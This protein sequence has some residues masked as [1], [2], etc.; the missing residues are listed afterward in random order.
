[1]IL[2][3]KYHI[4]TRKC[5]N[6]EILLCEGGVIILESLYTKR[7]LNTKKSF[8]REILKVIQNKEIISFAGGLPN[9]ISFPIEELQESMNRVITEVGSDAFQYSTT[10]G[11][12][13]L[14]EGIRRLAKVIEE[15]QKNC[16]SN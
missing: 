12:L 7:I 2:G 4:I 1:M 3:N 8:I 16:I 11:H 9:P 13:G 14:R 5:N 10:E 6:P 15:E